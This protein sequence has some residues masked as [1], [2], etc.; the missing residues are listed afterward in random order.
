MPPNVKIFPWKLNHN[1]ILIK[2]F[3]AGRGIHINPICFCCGLAL[4]DVNHLFWDC[5]LTDLAWGIIKDWLG[6]NFINYTF[7]YLRI[8][9]LFN[10]KIDENVKKY[11]HTF[12]S[13]TLW[14]IWKKRNDLV[15]INIRRSRVDS[16]LH[17]QVIVIQMDG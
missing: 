16:C 3:F 8:E 17:D 2:V 6:I 14:T 10:L 13:A 11:W 12:A 5:Y 9:H 1:I 4:E 15:F 7:Q